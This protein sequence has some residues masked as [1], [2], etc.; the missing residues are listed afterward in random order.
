LYQAAIKETKSREKDAHLAVR[1]LGTPE[2]VIQTSEATSQTVRFKVDTK[3]HLADAETVSFARTEEIAE[4]GPDYKQSLE[5]RY[6]A[7]F[8]ATTEE[9]ENFRFPRLADYS[10]EGKARLHDIQRSEFQ[11]VLHV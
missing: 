3:A 5:N 7:P 2:D 8:K 10:E 6:L 9:V 4:S 11:I 1:S